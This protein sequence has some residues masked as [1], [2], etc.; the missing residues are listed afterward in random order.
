MLGNEVRRR[1]FLKMFSILAV[2]IALWVVYGI[3]KQDFVIILAHSI[4]LCLLAGILYFKIRE[5]AQRHGKR[6]DSDGRQ[7]AIALYAV[8]GKSAQVGVIPA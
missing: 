6:I 5:M 8:A 3:L 4:S 2:G 1:P 7:S